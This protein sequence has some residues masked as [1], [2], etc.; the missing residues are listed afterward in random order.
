MTEKWIVPCNIKH[1]DIISHFKVSDTAVWKN[2]FSIKTG[3]V[4]YIYVGAP[5]GEIRYKCSVISDKVDEMTLQNNSYAIVK[6][7]SH[8]FYSKTV[9]YIQIKKVFEY[10]KGALSLAELK[11]H[12]LGQ[13]QIQARTDRQLQRYIDDITMKLG[14][15]ENAD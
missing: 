9:K 15:A 8:I 10:P 13:V 4:V 14:G 3:D 12:G 2:S 6:E 7:P 5:C 1:F 11:A